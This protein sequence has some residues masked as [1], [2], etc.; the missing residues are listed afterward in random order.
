[1]KIKG[2]SPIIATAIVSFCATPTFGGVDIDMTEGTVTLNT[3]GHYTLN[4]VKNLS[5]FSRTDNT[6]SFLRPE[7][8]ESIFEVTMTYSPDQSFKNNDK[9]TMAFPLGHVLSID[10]AFFRK[11]LNHPVNVLRWSSSKPSNIS[12][13]SNE[14]DR[15]AP[16]FLT[17]K[18]ESENE[19]IRYT[20]SPT[21]AV[22]S[23][24]N[25][26]KPVKG[27]SP[28]MIE[29]TF[30]SRNKATDSS[31]ASVFTG[32]GGGNTDEPHNWPDQGK[33]SGRPTLPLF[34]FMDHVQS[35]GDPIFSDYALALRAINH[36]LAGELV[37]KK[38]VADSH[39]L[40]QAIEHR[41]KII[42]VRM[43]Y[44]ESIQPAR[45]LDTAT[46][47]ELEP[48]EELANWIA[49]TLSLKDI[50]ALH[51]DLLSGDIHA[52]SLMS[53]DK[54]KSTFTEAIRNANNKKRRLLKVRELLDSW[55][56]MH[57]GDIT[58]KL[59]EVLANK[60]LM[61]DIPEP[62]IARF[63][64]TA[65][66]VKQHIRT[67]NLPDEHPIE[68][69]RHPVRKDPTTKHLDGLV[70]VLKKYNEERDSEEKREDKSEDNGAGTERSW[71]TLE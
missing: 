17:D 69:P 70:G 59:L 10:S 71:L 29:I 13:T 2:V 53:V 30:T 21:S 23:E 64:D 20:W 27:L 50:A 42:E 63:G 32:S 44:V 61:R 56:E 47:P 68:P 37:S 41:E 15:D 25:N 22:N 1:M 52:Q 55:K 51:R 57:Q 28:I 12:L 54:F 3:T 33:R 19:K 35:G 5:E 43:N 16:F 67:P 26:K 65:T 11:T 36:N 40:Q 48:L 6:Q 66:G 62:L 18:A 9:L 8:S 45:E 34:N 49:K 58:T 14:I 38:N 31:E 4:T 39:Y 7:D 46:L 60:G 24:E